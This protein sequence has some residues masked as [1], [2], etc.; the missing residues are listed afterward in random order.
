MNSNK[1]RAEKAQYEKLVDILENI[2]YS[3]KKQQQNSE[4][5]LTKELDLLMEEFEELEEDFD[6]LERQYTHMNETLNNQKIEIQKIK[7]SNSMLENE[8]SDN[9]LKITNLIGVM[10]SV[11]REGIA[12]SKELISNNEITNIEG[13]STNQNYIYQCLSDFTKYISQ[14]NIYDKMLNDYNDMFISPNLI[15]NKINTSQTVISQE[16]LNYLDLVTSPLD[17]ND[18]DQNSGI[19]IQSEKIL[20]RVL[21]YKNQLLNNKLDES[22]YLNEYRDNLDEIKSSIS[23]INLLQRSIT[24]ISQINLIPK[25][26]YSLQLQLK[27]EIIRLTPKIRELSSK[28]NMDERMKICQQAFEMFYN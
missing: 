11:I 16:L 3:V 12:S 24:D 28:G 8:T 18:N 23:S 26:I 10:D 22:A 17:N 13:F 7:I 1:L 14:E 21:K 5:S 19:T 2:G 9:D 4:W 15:E 6:L 27:N 25:V 20:S